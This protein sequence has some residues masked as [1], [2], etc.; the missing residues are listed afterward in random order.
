MTL[1]ERF[2]QAGEDGVEFRGAPFWSWNDDL[3]PDELRRQVRLQKE[4]GL[5]GYFMHARVGLITPYLGPRWM[6]CIAATV[7]E[8][9]K[10]D[11]R[12]WLYDEDKWPSGSVGRVIP[13]MGPEWQ[14]K[15]L[16]LLEAPA[17]EYQPQ[18]NA[19]ATFVGV[20]VG[21]QLSE[22][23]RVPDHRVSPDEKRTVFHFF[24]QPVGY[25]DLLKPEVVDKFIELTHE[26][27]KRLCGADFGDAIPGIFTDE[28]NYADPP[29]TERLPEI[30]RRK[31]GYDVIEHLLSLFYHVGDTHTVR[32]DFWRTV[33]DLYVQTFSKR[34]YDWCEQ[35]HLALTGH[36][37]YEDTLLY[38]V[39][40]V[41]S[42]MQHYEYMQVPGIDH[43]GRNIRDPLLNKQVSSVA[44]QFGGRRVL[45]ETYGCSGWN[46]SFE[47]QKWIGDW[48]YVM[49]VNLLCHHLEL[50]S[51]KGR[52]KRDYPPSLFY[53]QPW[54]PHNRQIA[55]YFARLGA[56][57]TAGAHRAEILLVHPM[58]SAWAVH[59]PQDEK[60]ALEVNEPFSRL[61]TYLLQCHRDYD[62][63]DEDILERHA[64]VIGEGADT[65]LRVGTCEYPIVILPP[66]VT[67]RTRVL[68]MVLD[69][70]QR[71]GRLICV[72]PLPVEEHGR[73]T[74]RLAEC[75]LEHGQRIAN[76]L[77]EVRQILLDARP[78]EVI[79][80]EREKGLARLVHLFGEHGDDAETVYHHLRDDG[81]ERILFLANVD[82]DHPV[83]TLV[84]L[85][86]A[87]RL[88]QW[89]P[90]TGEMTPLFTRFNEGY[91]A[92]EIELAP[93]G[94]ALLVLDTTQPALEGERPRP[95]EV[96]RV[97]FLNTWEIEPTEPNA[98]TLD[99][100]DFRLGG[101]DWIE[102]VPTIW[103]HKQLEAQAASAGA[104]GSG[105]SLELRFR[106]EAEEAPRPCWLVVERTDVCEIEVNGAA[107]PSDDE[108]W[109]CDIAFRK[110]PIGE[111]LKQGENAITVRTRLEPSADPASFEPESAYVI[112]DFSVVR[113]GHR[114]PGG[115][116]RFALRAPV[117]R[118]DS[119]DLGPQGF[120]FYRGS[121]VYRQTV[122]VEAL[123][124][125]RRA[126]LEFPRLEAIVT[127]V[128]VNGEEAGHL[129]WR[130]W[131]LDVT[132]RL[133]AGRNAFEI[134]VFS[135][136]RNLLGPHHHSEG[137]LTGV[138]P[139][140]FY[141]GNA[142]AADPRAEDDIWRDEY[143]FVPFGIIAAPHLSIQSEGS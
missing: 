143:S 27:Y 78:P 92:A 95:R 123:E 81:D 41:G 80:L 140:S 4:A 55:D 115:A 64:E 74:E 103:V 56:A 121:V 91:T 31:N 34:I 141:G 119:G 9:K 44:H 63:G 65:R 58:G 46:L 110:I 72:D 134:E 33:T 17:D 59:D 13:E 135:S 117:A 67:I 5:G 122:S 8:G 30:F 43:L 105:R 109:W 107:V 89:D 116:P 49:G 93:A 14:Q 139:R 20:R 129:P 84:K 86:G 16:Q 142:W 128:S 25:A 12:S 136:C 23:E 87:G 22:V 53:Q 73:E 133:Q 97:A 2:T 100:C 126:V 106:F 120:P 47:G 51:M 66:M 21:K 88:E 15:R 42:C 36:Q 83:D 101:G 62:Y 26:A 39:R 3:D 40:R 82:N 98:L 75:L 102:D 35:N 90:R 37:L 19:L 71:G 6:E 1:R 113:S 45:S 32:Y 54:W 70:A 29:W 132:D 61:S 138:G 24:W 114:W 131:R 69:F 112:G 79:V 85:R 57:L 124:A 108:G 94:S 18:A 99:Y 48:Q 50:Y 28:P 10:A 7:D 125:G 118:A 52:R 38:Q 11:I 127:R 111:H 77:A 68:E 60:P 137:E 130:P 104:S 76:D 96:R